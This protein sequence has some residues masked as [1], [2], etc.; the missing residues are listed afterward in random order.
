MHVSLVLCVFCMPMY[1]VFSYL[2]SSMVRCQV[3]NVLLW[4]NRLAACL[5]MALCVVYAVKAC[6]VAFEYSFTH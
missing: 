5:E 4:S 3:R 1:D 6:S 2:T